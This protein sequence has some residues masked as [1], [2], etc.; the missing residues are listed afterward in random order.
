MTDTERAIVA[1]GAVADV[2]RQSL[3]PVAISM[4]AK[5]LGIWPIEAI[6]GCVPRM[7][8]A[9]RFFPNPAEWGEYAEAWQ[10]EQQRELR[11][12]RLKTHALTQDAESLAEERAEA[13]KAMIGALKDKLG[14]R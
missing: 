14:W 4:Y 6:E 1:V 13:A 8:Q 10:Q 11:A 7:L 12:Q 2:F 3:S 9:S 5:S